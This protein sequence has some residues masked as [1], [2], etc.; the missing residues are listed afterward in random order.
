MIFAYVFPILDIYAWLQQRR[1]LNIT[2]NNIFPT[3]KENGRTLY[4]V[5]K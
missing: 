4:K 3:S 2:S 5:A 1:A